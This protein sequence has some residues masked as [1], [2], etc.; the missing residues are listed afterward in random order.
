MNI[1]NYQH[2]YALINQIILDIWEIFY[3]KGLYKEYIKAQV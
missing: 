3:L 1:Y 2:L